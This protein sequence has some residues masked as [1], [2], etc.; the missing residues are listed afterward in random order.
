VRRRTSGE[1]GSAGQN[2]LEGATSIQHP[3]GGRGSVLNPFKPEGAPISQTQF[4]NLVGQFANIYRQTPAQRGKS[5]SESF[6]A[7]Q[8]GGDPMVAQPMAAL[9]RETAKGADR[10]ANENPATLDP[11]VLANLK[12]ADRKLREDFTGWLTRNRGSLSL[13]ELLDFGD[14]LAAAHPEREDFIRNMLETHVR[15]SGDNNLRMELQEFKRTGDT[16]GMGNAV[17]RNQ[18][19]QNQQDQL[20]SMLDI[21]TKEG[22]TIHPLLAEELG[23]QDSKLGAPG[24]VMISSTG[25]EVPATAALIQQA[26]MDRWGLGAPAPTGTPDY[27]PLASAP[28]GQITDAEGNV[29]AE[30]GQQP[31]TVGA[32]GIV[33]AEGIAA[34]TKDSQGNAIV[35]LQ[36]GGKITAEDAD[37]VIEALER[38]GDPADLALAEG[39]REGLGLPPKVKTAAEINAM[40]TP[41][42]AAPAAPAPDATPEVQLADQIVGLS[43]KAAEDAGYTMTESKLKLGDMI[44]KSKDG[45]RK[46]SFKQEATMASDAKKKAAVSVAEAILGS[47][48]GKAQ[49]VFNLL[50]RQDYDTLRKMIVD[51]GSMTGEEFDALMQEETR[52]EYEVIAQGQKDKVA[53]WL[54]KQSA[55]KPTQAKSTKVAAASADEARERLRSRRGNA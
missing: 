2:P 13:D 18:Y 42:P 24:Y 16:A 43:H 35:Q 31:D 7:H 44:L 33:T 5:F 45:K 41:P 6:V 4:D 53:T 11:A 19:D 34:V 55:E 23:L 22:G 8:A 38:R 52:E 1:G 46:I 3:A 49:R 51:K 50:E 47:K 21:A 14:D 40:G 26:A 9:I 10:I 32:A 17:F 36:N 39:I 27:D 15:T 30:A 37:P 25:E 54:Q 20:K 48:A 29:I 28:T 12:T